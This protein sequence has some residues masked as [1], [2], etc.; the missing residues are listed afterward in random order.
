MANLI[1]ETYK[2]YVMSHGN[3]IFNIAFDMAMEN[4]FAYP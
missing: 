4:M 2:N 1:F 3:N